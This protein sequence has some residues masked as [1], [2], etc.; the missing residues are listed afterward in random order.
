M[1]TLI[2]LILLATVAQAEITVTS[3]PVMVVTSENV[4]LLGE[5]LVIDGD[6]IDVEPA[7]IITLVIDE[8]RVSEQ[9][10]IMIKASDVNRE[11]VESE[12]ADQNNFIIPASGKTWIDVTII[13]F[14]TQFFY[15]QTHL[16]DRDPVEPD[17][18]LTGLAKEACEKATG[19]LSPDK[20]RQWAAT[21]DSVALLISTNVLNTP[22]A[23]NAELKRKLASVPI[24][25]KPFGDWLYATLPKDPPQI[26]TSLKA[27]AEG[28]RCVK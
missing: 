13:D 19:R 16:V 7:S 8:P 26:E 17:K 27:I 3:R 12:K 9:A 14:T 4:E 15:Q 23:I 21:F 2:A 28:L 1:K 10:S 11:P 6:A 22:E 24:S 18:P 25:A 20:A 5:I